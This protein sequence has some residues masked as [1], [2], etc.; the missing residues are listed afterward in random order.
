MNNMYGEWGMGHGA[1]GIGQN[2]FE[3]RSE[4]SHSGRAKRPAIHVQ[5]SALL[6]PT[7]QDNY[8]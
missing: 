2:S 6:L 3:P 1:L 7:P 4:I 5:H 8:L